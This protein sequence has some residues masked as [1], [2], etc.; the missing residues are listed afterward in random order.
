MR[1]ACGQSNDVPFQIMSASTLRTA[2][3]TQNS[4]ARARTGTAREV[5]DYRDGRKQHLT[6][7][8]VRCP[9]G[10]EGRGPSTARAAYFLVVSSARLASKS[11]ILACH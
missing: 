6:Q 1:E 3:D 9:W 10:E 7:I 4:A 11:A 8:T 2:F 5:R